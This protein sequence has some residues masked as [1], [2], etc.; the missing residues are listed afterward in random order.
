MHACPYH[1]IQIKIYHIPINNI[2]SFQE[3]DKVKSS[4]KLGVRKFGSH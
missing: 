4:C 1:N 3:K 2:F